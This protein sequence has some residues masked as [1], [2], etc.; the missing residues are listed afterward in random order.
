[1]SENVPPPQLL[2][3]DDIPMDVAE[4]IVAM[5][6]K[7][8]PGYEVVFAGDTPESYQQAMAPASQRFTDAVCRA[9]ADGCCFYCG[10]AMQGIPDEADELAW[11]DWK[12]PQD[13]GFISIG[14][15]DDSPIIIECPD[16]AKNINE[17]VPRKV[18]SPY[19]SDGADHE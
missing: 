2:H 10:K 1:M 12:P 9:F 11:V 14:P 6:K 15:S 19:L 17:G 3:R 8:H 16:C 18:N 4:E 13:W 7:A 5:L